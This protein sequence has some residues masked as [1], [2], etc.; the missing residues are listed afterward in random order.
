MGA[1]SSHDPPDIEDDELGVDDKYAAGVTKRI[2][3]EMKPRGKIGGRSGRSLSKHK[4]SNSLR[5]ALS[6]EAAENLEVER[7]TKEFEMYRMKCDSDIANIR[8]K[9]QKLETENR[10]LRAELQALQKMC[11]KQRDE[12]DSALDAE[13][14]ALMRAAAIEADRDKVQRQFKIFRETKESELQNLLRAKRNLEGK[15]AKLGSSVSEDS[16]SSSRIEPSF[17]GMSDWWSTLDSEQ[18]QSELGQ[19]DTSRCNCRGPELANSFCEQDGLCVTVRKDDWLPA[20]A[21]LS[22]IL[23]FVPSTLPLSVI[24]IFVIFSSQQNEDNVLCSVIRTKLQPVCCSVGLFL[25]IVYLPDECSVA[26]DHELYSRARYWQLERSN[27]LVMV[28]D[29]EPNQN[30]E[31]EI[32]HCIT[33]CPTKRLAVLLTDDKSEKWINDLIKKLDAVSTNLKVVSGCQTDED[34]ASSAANLISEFVHQEYMPNIEHSA[35]DK[36]DSTTTLF[37]SLIHDVFQED[38][39]AEI[40]YLA[41]QSSCKL[42]LEKY[43]ELLSAHVSGA[44]PLPPLLVCGSRGSGKS[45]LLANWIELQRSQSSGSLF[46]YHFVR[47]SS[48]C[49]ANPAMMIRRLTVQ[50][51]QYVA[52]PPM[53]TEDPERLKQEFP[54][55][56]EKVSS[57]LPGGIVLVIDAIDHFQVFCLHAANCVLAGGFFCD[58]FVLDVLVKL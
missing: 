41:Q 21:S 29:K 10:K 2:P 25:D 52:C 6:V 37:G 27:I 35:T 16:E 36:N 9:E 55:W 58:N 47:T 23:Y 15:L 44:G 28:T 12:R 26:V 22:N 3:V 30:T 5:S 32:N 49:S 39:Q 14:R 19:M 33:R 54:R 40:L 48:P 18:S 11:K 24:R 8:K 7:V 42:G 46:L 4:P 20:T 31:A 38:E 43:Y 34:A 1:S 45:L 56:L 57:R 13:H 51:M 50:L 53:T 17:N